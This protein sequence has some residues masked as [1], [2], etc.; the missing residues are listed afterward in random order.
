MIPT[1]FA[2]FDG[3]QEAAQQQS[4]AD[5]TIQVPNAALIITGQV[6]LA[7]ADITVQPGN[8]S[9]LIDGRI[10]AIIIAPRAAR[11]RLS[12]LVA[13]IRDYTTRS[14]PDFDGPIKDFIRLAEQR[15]YYGGD[16]PLKTRPVR[17]ADMEEE[18]T[19]TV[20]NGSADLPEDFL[21]GARLYWQTDAAT[22][23]EYLS[24]RDFHNT[25]YQRRRDK[26]GTPT[27]YTIEDD[28]IRVAYHAKGDVDLLYLKQFEP[29]TND[30]DTNPILNDNFQIYLHASLFEAF[31]FTRNGQE[32]KKHFDMFKQAADA[33]TT[34][35]IRRRTSGQTLE[36]RS[37][38]K[39]PQDRST[40]HA[41]G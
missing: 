16:E 38:N 7:G 33:R 17:M 37:P 11:Y 39:P 6:P 35:Y 30:Q 27:F 2:W 24:R 36:A 10:P 28:A 23:I 4:T 13:Q 1:P 29:L 9:L 15:I 32:A 31:S 3:D 40:Y 25:H 18:A 8:A 41:Y 34:G 21:E 14:N 22:P 20:T 12:D 5:I 19:L 26:N